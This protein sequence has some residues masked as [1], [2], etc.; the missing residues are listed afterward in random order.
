M[1]SAFERL[2]GYARAHH[3]KLSDVAANVVEERLAADAVLQGV[4]VERSDD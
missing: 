1:Q 2:R 3:Q 4:E